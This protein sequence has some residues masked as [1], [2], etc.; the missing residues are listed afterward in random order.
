MSRVGSLLEKI[1]ATPQPDEVERL[2]RRAW[3]ELG[4]AVLRPE[5]IGDEWVAQGVKGEAE[6]R[7]GRR[8]A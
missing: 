3:H 1:Q 8:R 2:K 5:E 6:R 4:L 7:Y